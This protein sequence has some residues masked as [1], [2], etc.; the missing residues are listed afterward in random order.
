MY[1]VGLFFFS[2]QSTWL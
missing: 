2:L 1:K